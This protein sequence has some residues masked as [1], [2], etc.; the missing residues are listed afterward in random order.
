[1]GLRFYFGGSGSGKSTQLYKKIIERSIQAP[2]Q[3][4]LIIVP[5][6]FTMQTQKDLVMLHPNGGIMN[7]DVLSFG[8]LS[9]RIFEE[10]GKSEQTVLD[11]TGKSLV[12]RK[13]AADIKE[14][15]PVLGGNL[16]K[17]GYIHEVKSAI[18]EFMQYGI[19]VKELEQLIEYA[20]SRG[21][22]YHKLG[23]LKVLY[24]EFLKYI[25]GQFITT[26]ETLDKLCQAVQESEIIKHSV[27][28]FD[29]FTGFTPIQNRLIGELM[30]L[31]DEVILTLTLDARENPYE[32]GGEQQLFYLSK[33]TVH[34]LEKYATGYGVPRR[35]DVILTETPRFQE[36][37]GLAHLEKALFRYPIEIY[38]G[39]D[40]ESIHIFETTSPKEEVRQCAIKIRELLRKENYQFRDIAVVTGDLGAY[41]PHVEEQFSLFEIPCFL[42]T[43]R[44]IVLNPFI[45]YI[46]SALTI[47]C[48]DF[49]YEAVFH[50]LRSGLADFTEEEVDELENYVLRFHLRGKKC[51]TNVFTKKT[52]EMDKDPDSFAR[53]NEY[54][55]RL[56]HQ[57]SALFMKKNSVDTYIQGL[58]EFLVQ[59]RGQEKLAVFEEKFRLA[60]DATREREYAQ[61]YPR[62]MDLLDQ[63]EGLLAD[64]VMTLQDFFDILDAGFGEI[65][66]GMIPQNV[67]RVVVGDIERTRLKEVKALFFLGVNDGNIPKSMSKGGIISDIDRE[68]LRESQWELAPSP[69]QQVYTQRLYLYLNMT[70]PT[71]KL[72]VSY[73]QVNG[74]GKSLRPAYLI[75]TL[76][77]L[78]PLLTVEKPENM[79]LIK[80]ME[81]R[82]ESLNLLAEKLRRYAENYGMDEEEKKFFH[83]LYK[84]YQENEEYKKREEKLEQAAFYRYIHHPLARD[85]ARLLYGNTLMNSVTRLETYAACAYEHF[86]QYGLELKEREEFDFE[87]V[88]MGN[89]FHG[90]LE[91]FSNKLAEAGYTWF[92]FSKEVGDK[93]VEQALET[94]AAEY[95]DTVLYSSARNEY[96]I[97]RMKR[98]LKRTIHTLQYQLKKGSFT[99]TEFEVSFLALEDLEAVNIALSEKEKMKL[100]GRIDRVDTLEDSGHVY[101]KIIDYKSGNK[102]FDLAALYYGLSLQLVVYMNAAV[103]MEQKKHPDK[104]VVPAAMLY[105]H[106][107]DPVVPAEERLSPEELNEKL[108]SELRMNG[109]VNADETLLNKLDAYI[110]SKSDV[111][112]VER[113]KD[114]SL[115]ARSGVMSEEEITTVSKYV[116]IKMKEIGRE[117][118][119]GNIAITPYEKGNKSA[120]TYCAFKAVCGYDEKIE[121]FSRLEL[122]DIST[123]QA[124]EKMTEIVQKNSQEELDYGN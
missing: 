41:A 124:Y 9:H 77:K 72:Y 45:E 33:K 98:I 57:L 116:D 31:A 73:S 104:Q 1:M 60:G 23:D 21:A 2:K 32:I 76:H 37:S 46:R 22:L 66:V 43:T 12:L 97:L 44:G 85:I 39:E 106:I 50:Y 49:S 111:I 25:D 36:G 69:R 82:G 20:G 27:I 3:N 100:R 84:S 6:Q 101:V 24:R 55:E 56:C 30:R 83:A 70:K 110:G 19:G 38:T 122:E 86:L 123:E 40:T 109:V 87:N 114:G 10:V 94:Y 79:P 53:I 89:V 4:F 78:F 118:F 54:R 90:V 93:L 68:F 105:Y 113:K 99:P 115:S 15:L 92:D 64:E 117:I 11:D 62:V 121:G 51:Y 14:Q 48:K 5:D 28:V 42:D 81:T 96:A 18:S 112:P 8:R 95:G 107:A 58:Y 13:V 108:L 63:I 120:C 102:Q 61:I 7:I 59:N 35:E 88:D 80:Q 47:L 119:D 67:D 17:Q 34:D 74:E 75:D 52:K 71:R 91:Q 103:A 16:D 26:E 29:G 65:Q